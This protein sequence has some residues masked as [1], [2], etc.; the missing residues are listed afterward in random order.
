MPAGKMKRVKRNKRKAGPI[1]RYRPKY[2]LNTLQIQNVR[3]STLRVP[4]EVKQQF[5][6]R[7]LASSQQDGICLFFNMSSP[8]AISHTTGATS[9]LIYDTTGGTNY[10][11]EIPQLAAMYQHGHV[12]GSK[13]E[14]SIKFLQHRPDTTASGT[15]VDSNPN[16]LVQGVYSGIT[17]TNTFPTA[18]TQPNTLVAAHNFRQQRV[19]CGAQSR[20]DWNNNSQSVAMS[21]GGTKRING[22]CNYSPRKILGVKDV[23]DVN[24]LKFNLGTV[25]G[26][27]EETFACVNVQHDFSS[28]SPTGAIHKTLFNDFYIDCKVTY[29]VQVSEPS[30]TQGDNLMVQPVGQQ[31]NVAVPNLANRHR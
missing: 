23:T 10:A 16:E 4:I 31:F 30:V 21:Q 8:I 15:I 20:Y 13:L 14:Y 17:K 7:G 25:T 11:N 29:M 22:V 24:D 6:C 12:L 27:T 28:T 26:S 3:P 5:F 2:T 1:G 9:Q 18:S 19:L